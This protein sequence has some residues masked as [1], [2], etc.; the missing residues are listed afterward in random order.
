MAL[1]TEK[2]DEGGRVLHKRSRDMNSYFVNEV[3]Y[4][5]RLGPPFP[6]NKILARVIRNIACRSLHCIFLS[7]FIS[8]GFIIDPPLPLAHEYQKGTYLDNSEQPLKVTSAPRDLPTFS[9]LHSS[10]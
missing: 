10:P 2:D 6:I 8:H 4:Y 1:D 5:S 3:K 7:L 9:E